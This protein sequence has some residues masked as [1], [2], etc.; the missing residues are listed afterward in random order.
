M[1]PELEENSQGESN[2]GSAV[3]CDY[4]S[5]YHMMGDVLTCVGEWKSSRYCFHSGNKTAFSSTQSALAF[6]VY[7]IMH[8]LKDSEYNNENGTNSEAAQS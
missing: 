3:L 2:A 5:I 8:T 4:F 6:I 7:Y 1:S